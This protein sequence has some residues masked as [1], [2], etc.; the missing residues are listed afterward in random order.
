MQDRDFRAGFGTLA[1]RKLSF[2]TMIYHPQ[3]PELAELARAFP[4]TT[5]VLNHIGGLIAWTRNYVTRKEEAI[6]QWR[7]SMA[8]LAKCPNVFVKL[9]GLGMPYLGLGLD[10]L[11][12]PASSERL[13]EAWGPLFEHCID[14]FGPDRCMFESNFPPDRESADYP[15]LWN[16]FKRIAAGYSA[17]E[18]QA[19]FYG[20]AAKAY[21]LNFD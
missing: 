13:A 10:K 4:D 14:K 8:D 5:I 2:D 1:P 12:V 19:L 17:G 3:I 18:K 9:G 21:R 7:S 6:A 11:E 16:A 20:T 15:I